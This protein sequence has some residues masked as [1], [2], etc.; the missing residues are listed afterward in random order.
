[1]VYAPFWTVEDG[2]QATLRIRNYHVRKA[3]TV[4]PVLYSIDGVEIPLQSVRLSPQATVSLPLRAAL[5]DA[6][7]VG[8][9]RPTQG[10]A[11]LRY[12]S[13]AASSV[14]ATLSLTQPEKSLTFQFTFLGGYAGSASRV[15]ESAWWFLDEETQG[16]VVL[17]NTSGKDISV[18]PTLFVDGIDYQVDSLV[19]RAHTGAE[20]DLRGALRNQGLQNATHGGVRLR[21]R[22]SQ[23]ALQAAVLLFDERRGFSHQLAFVGH[24]L[25]HRETHP[26]FAQAQALRLHAPHVMLGSPAAELGFAPGTGFT[27]WVLLR[28]PTD[29]KI[30]LDTRFTYME[31]GTPVEV[32]LPINTLFAQETLL[33]DISRFVAQGLIP[34]GVSSGSLSVGYRG[35][36]NTVLL[37]VASLDQTGNFVQAASI[38]RGGLG[39]V[40]GVHWRTDG[41]YNTLVTV[42]NV[43]SEAVKVQLTLS[44]K[45]GRGAFGVPP[46]RL[47]PGAIHTFNLKAIQAQGQPDAE[48]NQW[49]PEATAGGF[50]LEA[51]DAAARAPLVTDVAVYNPVLGTCPFPGT[52]ICFGI[53]ETIFVPDATV[54]TV[55]ET[56]QL[57]VIGIWNTGQEGDVTVVSDFSSS[58]PGV[59]S[60]QNG[61]TEHGLATC[62]AVGR[63]TLKG[64]AVLPQGGEVDP[65]LDTICVKLLFEAFSPGKV[66]T[67]SQSPSEFNMSTGDTKQ[68]TVSVNP[69]T[70][71]V[72]TSFTTNL[73]NPPGNPDS[74]CQ[75][76]LSIPGKTGQGNIAH[77]V[78]ASP[79]GCSGVFSTRASADGVPST[80]TTTVRIPPQKIIQ[81]IE[82]EAGGTGNNSAM[83]AVA[84]VA[85]NRIRDT[86]FFD[87]D[88]TYQNTIRSGQFAFTGTA[89]GI[90]PELNIAVGVFT[91]A[92]QD[93]TCGSLAFWSPTPAEWQI[94][95]DAIAS[96]QTDF[97]PGTGAPNFQDPFQSRRQIVHIQAVG[98]KADGQ[99]NFLFLRSRSLTVP[100][101]VQL[102]CQ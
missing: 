15:L 23:Y 47:A 53:I 14:T 1:M 98:F 63:A 99:P 71:T 89:T 54:G 55:G 3:V 24:D 66:I 74:S 4:A 33:V 59:I 90:Q 79:A 6:G 25:F 68:I 49:P 88:T 52:S 19:L 26:A 85:R 69:S 40:G 21:Y 75:A 8:T 87:S 81:M 17:F 65:I 58:H 80:N 45:Q 96:G 60:V 35:Y 42:Q 11:A 41:N 56:R 76:S 29:G 97:P 22:G 34:P 94:V 20:I 73:L 82:A 100:A 93:N 95:Q 9:A 7:F 2:F 61:G 28:N 83:T 43:E 48:G 27:P 78:S 77:N 86:Q 57:T 70:V 38:N 37:S 39:L 30:A 84:I 50:L 12:R 92:T 32:P 10:G 31:G 101:A 51:G 16:R 46:V 18:A 5:A 13:R 91:G 36:L 67:V 64:E 62:N 72:K 102:V 44:F